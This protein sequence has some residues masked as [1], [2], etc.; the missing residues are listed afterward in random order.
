MLRAVLVLAVLLIAGCTSKEPSMPAVA[1]ASGPPAPSLAVAAKASSTTTNQTGTK[2]GEAPSDAVRNWQM[3]V[4]DRLQPFMK[5]PDDAPIHVESASP[6]VQVT[7]D[8]QGRVLN[9]R[10][11]KSCGFSSFDIA[12]RRIFKRAGTLPAPPPELTGDPLSFTMAVT[13]TQKGS[14][15]QKG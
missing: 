3:R 11:V 10:I 8:R 1:S 12:A 13:F 2:P 9:A 6:L 5:W 7:I 4:I 14:S 15:A